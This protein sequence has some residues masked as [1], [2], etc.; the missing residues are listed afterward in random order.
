MNT[1]M[2]NINSNQFRDRQNA[3][4]H[5]GAK[6]AAHLSYGNATLS[7]DIS[8]RLRVARQQAVAKHALCLRTVSATASSVQASGNTASMNFGTESTGFWGYVASVLPLVVLIAG[9]LALSSLQTDQSAADSA[10]V[11]AAIL[12]DS[13][14]AS[15][16]ADAGFAQFLKIKTATSP[17]MGTDKQDLETSKD[18]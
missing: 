4:D 12:T 8:E 5:F 13:L 2:T 18:I 17:F 7:H 3:Q 11:D 1:Y 6:V 15:A 16:Y 14:P 10:E 9:L